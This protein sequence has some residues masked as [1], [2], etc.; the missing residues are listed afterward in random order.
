MTSQTYFIQKGHL[1]PKIAKNFIFRKHFGS[2]DNAD[3]SDLKTNTKNL[4]RRRNERKSEI[5]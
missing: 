2:V 3:N 4:A 5:T 1:F